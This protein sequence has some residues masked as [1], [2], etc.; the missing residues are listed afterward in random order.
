MRRREFIATLVGAATAAIPLAARGQT[1]AKMPKIGVLWHAATEE[2]EAVY[3]AAV[4]RGL[5]DFGY[6]EGKNIVLENRYP[7]EVPERF[8]SLA[9]D[10]ATL[11]VDVLVAINRIAALAAQ[12]ATSTIPI[13]FVAIPDPVGSKLV[14]SLAR[15]GGNITGLSN[16]AHDLTSKRVEHLKEFVPS[17]SKVALLVNPNDKDSARRNIEEAQSA[18]DKLGLA[19]HPVEI[20][21]AGDLAPA[22]SKMRE[23]RINGVVVAQD[24]LFFATRKDIADLALAHHLP[25]AVYSRETVEAGALASYGPSNLNIFRRSGYY[26]DK[27]LKGTKP[28]DLPVEQPTKFEFIINLKTAK[29]LGLAVPPTLLSNA[30]D[31][32]E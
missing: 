10:L 21:A 2:E 31:V 14:A 24:G 6:F 25:L 22:F 23:D 29:A 4:R 12:R 8:I 19:L 11:K 13:V 27:I 18:A 3:L 26:I 28:L 15:P 5:S 20:R 17:V 7:A 16:F 30:D 1:T 9:A 32:I